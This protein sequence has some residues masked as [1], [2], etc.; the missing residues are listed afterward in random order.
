MASRVALIFLFLAFVISV[1]IRNPLLFLLNLVLSEHHLRV[2]AVGA[3]LFG[4]G[5]LYA[6]LYHDRLFPGEETDFWIE[7]VNA[8]PMPLTWLRAEDEIPYGLGII[9]TNMPHS[10]RPQRRILT[11]LFSLRWYERVRRRYRLNSEVRGAFDLGPV[12]VTSGDPFGFRIR[13]REIIVRQTI[14]VY[15]KIVSIDQFGLSPARPMGDYGTDR[16]IIEDPWRVA[17]ARDYQVGRQRALSALEGHG[18]SRHAANQVV[19]SQCFAALD[20]VS[21]HADVGTLIRRRHRR[22]SG[23]G[24]R[25]GRLDRVAGLESRR[26]VGLAS[27]SAVREAMHWA[28][29]PA[30]RHA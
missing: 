7:V 30:S 8:K 28:Y 21:Q 23:N 14:L 5:D 16:R 15:P 26:S 17:G 9:H 27:N 20:D 19:R 10:A 1:A 3:L 12:F 4:G 2:L 24:H 13:R 22:L 11:N 25:D 6:P 18:A 29:L